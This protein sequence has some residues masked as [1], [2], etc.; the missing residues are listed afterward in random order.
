MPT[1]TS[2]EIWVIVGE[3]LGYIS[4]I[5]MATND[6]VIKIQLKVFSF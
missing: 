1:L 6:K 4:S 5:G 2:N 3:I